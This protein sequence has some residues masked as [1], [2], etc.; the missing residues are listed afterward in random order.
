MAEYFKDQCHYAQ[1]RYA[2]GNFAVMLCCVPQSSMTLLIML[3]FVMLIALDLSIEMLI[4]VMLSFGMPNVV[5]LK[6]V[7]IRS[8]C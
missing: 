6:V 2:D 5:I 3:S 7:V 1:C 4:V 8:L